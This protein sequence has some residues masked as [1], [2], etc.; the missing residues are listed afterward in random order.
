MADTVFLC[1]E[2]LTVT[3]LE[4]LVL[5]MNKYINHLRLRSAEQSDT[6][7]THYDLQLTKVND[8][9]VV[10]PYQTL[11]LVTYLPALGIMIIREV[12]FKIIHMML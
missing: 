11:C 6:L 2:L 3:L 5:G 1:I 7:V 4:Y 12:I 8:E 10:N 9:D